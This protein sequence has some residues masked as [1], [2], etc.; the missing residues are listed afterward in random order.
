M[1]PEIVNSEATPPLLGHDDD[2]FGKLTEHGS[3]NF[4]AFFHLW[5]FS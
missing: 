2:S 5:L 1:R 3:E 4:L